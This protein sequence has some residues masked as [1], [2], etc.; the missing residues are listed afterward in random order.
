MLLISYRGIMYHRYDSQYRLS[1]TFYITYSLFRYHV[2]TYLYNK[3]LKT[4]I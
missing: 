1:E 2:E 3:E 4:D